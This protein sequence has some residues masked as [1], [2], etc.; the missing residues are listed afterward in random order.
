MK[1]LIFLLSLSCFASLKVI[2]TTSN[3]E[4]LAMRVGGDKVDVL[5]LCKGAQDPHFLEA[6]PSYIFK[7][8]RADLLISVGA[9]LE[10][11]W[12]PLIIQGSRKPSLRVGQS[13]HLVGAGSVKLIE[14]MTGSLSRA[15]GDV[16]PAGNPHYMLSP[17][18]SVKVAKAMS[19][20]FSQ[21]DTINSAYYQKNFEDYR[22]LINK[23]MIE[24][25]KKI[26]PGLK[27]I[28]YHRTLSYFYRDFGIVNVDVLEPKPGVPPSAS[29]IIGLIKMMKTK[30]VKK[31]IVENY[32]SEAVALRIKKDIPDVVINMVPVAVG[33]QKGIDNLIDLYSY[34]IKSVEK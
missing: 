21:I 33:G 20:K 24:W 8:S 25:K 27:V 12:L 32:F 29:H 22:D 13:N 34:L 17:I 7:L 14:Q 30:N 23:K 19:D 16:H 1:I 11:G 3:L 6:K 9:D 31:I 18:E 28:T 15:Q 4:A 2:T 5:G 26:S 10:I